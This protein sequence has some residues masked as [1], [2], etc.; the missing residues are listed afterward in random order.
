MSCQP[1]Q[2]NWGDLINSEIE[3][4]TACEGTVHDLGDQKELEYRLNLLIDQV[5]R[6]EELFR[7]TQ[8]LSPDG[9]TLLRP[10]R[11]DSGRI[12]DFCWLFQN[13]SIAKLNGTDP[14]KIIGKRLLEV[15]PSHRNTELFSTYVDVAETGETRIIEEV[16]IG[17]IVD[18]PTW[19]RLVIVRVSEDIAIA[20]QDITRRKLAEVALRRSESQFRSIFDIA[21]LGIAQVDPR[22]GKILLANAHYESITGYRLD[23]LYAMTFYELTH[24]EDRDKDWEIFDLA[25][26]GE[27]EY[28]NEKRYVKKDG[29]VIWVRIHL[30]FIR[31][32]DGKAVRTVAICEN[33]SDRKEAELRIQDLSDH[34]PGVIFQYLLFPDGTDALRLVSEGARQLWGYSPAEVENNIDLVWDQTKAGG[35]YKRVVKSVRRAVKT[36]TKWQVRYRSVAPN[37]DIQIHLG[38]GTPN[39]W[40]DGT[41]CFNSVVLDIT[42]QVRNE[43]LLSQATSIARIG[44]WEVNLD[45]GVVI[46]SD[47]VH[48]LHETHPSTF[49]P[50]LDNTLTFYREDYRDFVR[51]QVGTCID[52]GT[53]FDFEAVLKT[54]G[55]NEIWVRAMGHAEFIKGR[56]KRIYGSI[57]DIHAQKTGE[58]QLKQSLKTLQDYQ[59]AID[60]SASFT[61][62]DAEGTIIDVNDHFCG[63]S[64]YTREELIGKTHQMINSRY[65]S[66][67]FF[68]GFWKTIKSGRIWRGEVRNQ[69]KDGSIYWVDTTVVPFLDENGVP[70]QFLALRI[71]VTARKLADDQIK[72]AYEKLKNIAWTQSHV[73]R[74]PLAKILGIVNIIDEHR[75]NLDDM[76][77]WMN[78]LR[79]SANEMDAV[80]K[81]IVE[82]A[83]INGSDIKEGT[84]EENRSHCR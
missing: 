18:E 72:E 12:I 43:E 4:A 77:L 3:Q 53:P 60:Q 34:L 17:E 59:F 73:V 15:F 22:Y 14:E 40:P 13:R 80:V 52:Q 23:E 54:A 2:G 26:R 30:A 11:E 8:E 57:Q 21:S 62:T 37:G 69:K 24:P 49:V 27:V 46:W 58:L 38:S 74:A 79:E 20:A 25:A 48:E 7:V 61:I 84:N 16:Y 6:S 9:C 29:T 68:D 19:L 39:Y 75:E 83:Q 65:H 81:K 78:Y 64:Q 70:F 44:S 47:M 1:L 51:A 41:V 67:K 5:R 55:N 63:L 50:D 76:L 36:K 82:E 33:I 31:D 42:Q 45:R 28:K 56:C 71:D 35:D 32:D 66:K 10:V